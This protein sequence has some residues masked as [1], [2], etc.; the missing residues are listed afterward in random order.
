MIFREYKIETVKFFLLFLFSSIIL[1]GCKEDPAQTEENID[2]DALKILFVGN[3]YMDVNNLPF[4]FKGFG[5]NS[6][7]KLF[8]GADIVLGTKLEDH[9]KSAATYSLVGSVKW[10]Y[11]ILQGDP[12]P[13]AYPE[14]EHLIFPDHTKHDEFFALKTMRDYIKVICTNAKIVYIM[15]WAYEDGLLWITGQTDTYEDMQKKIY[16]N[17]LKWCKDLDLIVAPVGWAWYDVMKE[18]RQIHYLFQ[19]DYNHPG[20]R[21]TYITASVL[22]STIYRRST[23]GIPFYS[24]L[25][26]DEA[27]Y[28]QQKSSKLVLDNLPLWNNNK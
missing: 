15:P 3:S 21:G 28:F 20:Q 19:D 22:Y 18:N 27:K 8:I 4:T 1:A 26:S 24:G 6:G 25:A 11:I 2:P 7:K 5:D 10:D 16:D 14:T 9:V 13:T 23:E 17:T 12:A